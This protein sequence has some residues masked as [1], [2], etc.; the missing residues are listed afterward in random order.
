MNFNAFCEQLCLNKIEVPLK[1]DEWLYA[2]SFLSISVSNTSQR[3][4]LKYIYL[5]SFIYFKTHFRT[6][7][8]QLIALIE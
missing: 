8:N 3:N 6:F 7:F 5:H 1:D 2:Q 4:V